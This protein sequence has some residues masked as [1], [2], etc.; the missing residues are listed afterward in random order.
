MEFL[1]KFGLPE[2]RRAEAWIL[3]VKELSPTSPLAFDQNGY[4]ALH[5]LI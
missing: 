3:G 1:F 4:M 2:G 5:L